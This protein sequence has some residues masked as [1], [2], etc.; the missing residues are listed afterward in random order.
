MEWQNMSRD[1]SG[2]MLGQINTVYLGKDTGMSVSELLGELGD[3]MASC[4]MPSKNWVLIAPNGDVH[5]GS[6]IQLL[7][8]IAK[9]IT[10]ELTMPS[11]TDPSDPPDR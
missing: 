9:D 11:Y 6:A 3:L 5:I 8:V 7:P 2:L 4:P 1:T 10:P